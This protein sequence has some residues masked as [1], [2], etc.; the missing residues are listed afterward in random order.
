M[1]VFMF[2]LLILYAPYGKDTIFFIGQNSLN[3]IKARKPVLAVKIKLLTTCEYQRD[4]RAAQSLSTISKSEC[5]A[6]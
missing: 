3:F 2:Y 6:K 5:R 4:Q 1:Y